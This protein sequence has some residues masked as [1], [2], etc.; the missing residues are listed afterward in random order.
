MSDAEPDFEV[1]AASLG[2]FLRLLKERSDGSLGWQGYGSSGRAIFVA[3][4]MDRRPS[5]Y[6]FPLV[7]R[8]VVA[9]FAHG[10][11]RF[12]YTRTT[13]N[14]VELPE[15]VARI[16]DRQQGAYEEVRA[17]IERGLEDS[18]LNVSVHEGFLHRAADNGRVRRD[19]GG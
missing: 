3:K 6:G 10:R 15:M 14:A 17:E 8:Y 16:E 5:Y 19:E 18:D 7:R 11:D 9:A 13:S 12:S 2:E 1:E 4:T